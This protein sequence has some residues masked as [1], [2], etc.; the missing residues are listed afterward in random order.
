MVVREVH[1]VTAES[2]WRWAEKLSEPAT[3]KKVQTH[4]VWAVPAPFCA[5]R[6]ISDPRY[7]PGAEGSRDRRRLSSRETNVAF[8]CATPKSRADYGEEEMFHVITL[9][10]VEIGERLFVDNCTK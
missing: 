2:F 3:Y 10:V 6:N 5:M 9:R 8:K 1:G 4:T 7:L